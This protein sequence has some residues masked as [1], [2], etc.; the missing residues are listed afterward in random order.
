MFPKVMRSR[1][2]EALKEYDVRPP[3]PDLRAAS[4]SGGNQQKAVL[5]RELSG[6]PGVIL[7]SQPTR[8]VDVGAIEFIHQ[9]LLEA[10]KRGQAILL[11]SLELDEVRSL[12]DRIVVMYRGGLSGEVTPDATDEQLGLLMA[13]RGPE[14]GKDGEKSA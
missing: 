13:G 6:E 10:R 8:G 9:R 1:A 11:V 7:A 14:W 3:E 2:A 5:A 12:A 4:L